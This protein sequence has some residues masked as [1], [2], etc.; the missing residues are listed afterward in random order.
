MAQAPGRGAKRSRGPRNAFT[1]F[2]EVNF[3]RFRADELARAAGDGD[4]PKISNH[5]V[6][7]AAR[8]TLAARWHA[9]PEDQKAL[10]LQLAECERRDAR[11]AAK[12]MRPAEP[13]SMGPPADARKAKLTVCYDGLAYHGFQTQNK[14]SI[15][16]VQD[17]VE[18]ALE[19][20]NG[21][22][23]RVRCCSRTDAGVHAEGN[24]LSARFARTQKTSSK[25]IMRAI[26]KALPEDIACTAFDWTDDSFDP[27]RAAK[28]KLYKYTIWDG[29]TR[30]VLG[31]RRMW[32]LSPRLDVSAMNSAAQ[33]L[34]GTHD[35]TSFAKPSRNPVHGDAKA[36]DPVKTV[37]KI[38]VTRA[39]S[40]HR[41]TILVTGKSFLWRM[42]R[43][44]VGGLVEVG[45]GR[46]S[47]EKLKTVLAAKDRAQSAGAAPA[48]GLCLMRVEYAHS[49]A[50]VA[51]D[52]VD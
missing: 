32:A 16:T 3:R 35:F 24:V 15:K 22:P 48:K 51:A 45:A 7:V 50:G 19:R 26:N 9:L 12:R 1:L 52:P 38:Q 47:P 18:S 25:A 41:V 34:V 28:L 33:C 42:V 27:R 4:R 21:W 20:V 14:E 10:Y 30:P 46:W 13:Q 6:N 29:P 23:Q 44:I 39:E 49:S 40:S 36:P 43:L 5:D 17:T 2:S 37:T 8:K 31:R 11:R